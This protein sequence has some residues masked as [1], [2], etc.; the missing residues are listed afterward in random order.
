MSSSD[1]GRPSLVKM[2]LMCLLTAFSVIIARFIPVVRTVIGP[3]CGSA[4][5]PAA[6]FT[7]WQAAGAAVWTVSTT[8]AGYLAARAVPGLTRYLVPALVLGMA[9][10]TAIT[11]IRARHARRSRT[12]QATTRTADD[13]SG[14]RRT[15]SR[16]A[17]RSFR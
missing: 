12:S 4:G 6:R 11:L 14:Q 5:L 2:L 3:L 17:I 13:P 9:V 1:G 16:S 7:R 15:S 8:L 10:S